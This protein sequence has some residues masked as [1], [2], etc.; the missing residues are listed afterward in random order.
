MNYW[1]VYLLA[2]LAVAVLWPRHGFWA[3]WRSARQLA[4]RVLREDAIKFIL[5]CEV[6]N[7][8]P[9]I[10]NLAGNLHL[11][12]GRTANLLEELEH[13]ALLSLDGGIL[14]LKPAGRELALHIIRAHRLWESYLSEQTGVGEVEWHQRAEHKE[15]HLSPTEADALAARLGNPVIDPHGDVIPAPGQTIPAESGVS[16]NAAEVYQPLCITHV[17]DEPPSIYAQLTAQGIRPGMRGLI[18]EKLPNRIRLWTD[19]EEHVLAPIMAN[20]IFVEPLQ[21]CAADD[22]LEEEYLSGLK[23]GERGRVINLSS[24]CRG[25]ERRRLLD[26]GFV[27]GTEVLAELRSPGGDPTAYRVRGTSIALRKGQAG[28]IR[29][30][31]IKPAAA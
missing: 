28:L 4:A 11:S 31:S 3:R 2:L 24:A 22:L 1:L 19:G 9:T 23:L 12:T 29:I 15:H 7:T 25:P 13:R 30:A 20:N 5:K 26:L 6:N 16:L 8:A 21:D 14:H 18:M 17:E 10:E 27:P